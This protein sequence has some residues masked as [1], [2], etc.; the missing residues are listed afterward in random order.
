MTVGVFRGG[1]ARQV[2][3]DHAELLIDLRA[4]T[5]IAADELLAGIRAVRRRR[6]DRRGRV[7]S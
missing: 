6:G 2:V 7:C 3:P 5:A 4:P 1:V